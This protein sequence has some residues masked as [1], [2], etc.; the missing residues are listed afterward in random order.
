MTW[1]IFKSGG[2]VYGVKKC[3]NNYSNC[4]SCKDKCGCNC[5]TYKKEDCKCRPR[6]NYQP[7]YKEKR[8]GNYQ[9][10]EKKCKPDCYVP[11]KP[12]KKKYASDDDNHSEDDDWTCPKYKK[13]QYKKDSYKKDSYKRVCKKDSYKKVA[14]DKK[15]KKTPCDQKDKYEKYCNEA[16]ICLSKK[17]IDLCQ[18]DT[19][20]IH[21]IA[22]YEIIIINKTCKT[23]C[24]LSLEDSFA[25]YKLST[26]AL[27][28]EINPDFT[29]VRPINY[30]S[31]TPY[32]FDQIVANNGNL[33][34]PCKSWVGP[35]D[36][37]RIIL[38]I[39]YKGY[40]SDNTGTTTVEC[41]PQVHTLFFCNTLTLRGKLVKADKCGCEI[42]EECF[43]PI[44][45]ET[46]ICKD[47]I[48]N[49]VHVRI[50]D[51]LTA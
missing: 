29:F 21:N 51:P 48:V 3:E 16:D 2:S 45:V 38:R 24:N 25:G 8:A 34:D 4:Y 5:K 18:T 42:E 40:K 35:C 14:C 22:T 41:D 33:V 37:V 44:T 10:A 49:H 36:T 39:A 9:C 19:G 46:T 27:A 11:Y 15:Y 12:E 30:P 26:N 31:V 23:I 17:L 28:S 13:E 20:D 50:N 47:A 1:E 6:S 7:D 43:V 32:T